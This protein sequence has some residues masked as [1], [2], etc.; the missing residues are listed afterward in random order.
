M[1][2]KVSEALKDVN[3]RMSRYSSDRIKKQLNLLL[4]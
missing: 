4:K 1:H 3:S 2:L